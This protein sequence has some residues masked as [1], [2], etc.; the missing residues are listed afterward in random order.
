M[1]KMWIKLF[2]HPSKFIHLMSKLLIL[3]RQVKQKNGIT[4]GIILYLNFILWKHQKHQ[5]LRFDILYSYFSYK[6]CYD[7][8]PTKKNLALK[9][10]KHKNL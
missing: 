5:L 2:L 10:S 8:I 1:L 7:I 3:G 9:H 4:R 6:L